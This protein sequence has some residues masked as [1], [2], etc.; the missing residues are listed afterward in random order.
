MIVAPTIRHTG[1]QW[2]KREL[3]C[4]GY[5]Q[6]TLRSDPAEGAF[7]TDHLY[8]THM[9]HFKK[10]VQAG[11]RVVIPLRHPRLV[12]ESWSKDDPKLMQYWDQ[13]WDNMLMFHSFDPEYIVVD[14]GDKVNAN[15]VPVNYDQ[16]PEWERFM[17]W[18]MIKER[19]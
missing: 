12:A 10:W 11:A 9:E 17:D 3:V 5:E 1:S 7:M 8:D 19:F 18:P 14:S 16:V 13:M 15:P 6:L 4:Q 2:L